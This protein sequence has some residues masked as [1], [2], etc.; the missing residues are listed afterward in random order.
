MSSTL[1]SNIIPLILFN[2]D[3]RCLVLINYQQRST[4]PTSE[5]AVAMSL[6]NHRRCW[7]VKK[8]NDKVKILRK[9]CFFWTY[10]DIHAS[11]R[12]HNFSIKPTYSKWVGKRYFYVHFTLYFIQ[13]TLIKECHKTGHFQYY[14]SMVLPMNR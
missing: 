9:W 13:I 2:E 7:K 3:C 1:G 6:W 14:F 8:I 5:W 4:R 11:H 12:S 10:Q